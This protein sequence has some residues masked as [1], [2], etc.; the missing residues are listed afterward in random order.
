MRR[1]TRDRGQ[2]SAGVVVELVAVGLGLGPGVVGVFLELV[3]GAQRGRVDSRHGLVGI[4]ERG[5]VSFGDDGRRAAGGDGIEE[6][7]EPAVVEDR[8]AGPS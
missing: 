6:G 3:D 2:L 5:A 4:G 7:H 8:S 1:S